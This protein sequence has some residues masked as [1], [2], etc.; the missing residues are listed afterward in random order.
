MYVRT[1]VSQSVCPHFSKSRKTKQ[2]ISTNVIATDWTVSLAEWF[3]D[4]ICLIL[5]SSL[6]R[7][8]MFG[9]RFRGQKEINYRQEEKKILDSVLG[10]DNY[11]KR[12]RP[13]GLNST[14]M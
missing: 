2:L 14:G 13:S 12:I 3:I 11:D 8:G 4:D 1:Y 10:K 5:F 6:S 9:N 7:A